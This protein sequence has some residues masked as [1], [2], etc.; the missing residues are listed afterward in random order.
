MPG[1]EVAKPKG[2]FYIFPNI[3][4]LKKTPEELAAYLLDHAQVAVVPGTSLGEYGDEFIRISYS[5]SYENLKTAMERMKEA[6][7]S[8]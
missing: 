7:R 3:K 6:I 5:N 4:A 1:I 2:A 8:L